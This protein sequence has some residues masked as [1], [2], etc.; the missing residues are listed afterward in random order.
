M[1]SN[2][3][4]E[5]FSSAI[6]L[7]LISKFLIERYPG[8]AEYPL[9]GRRDM[10]QSDLGYGALRRKL[11]RLGA[12]HTGGSRSPTSRRDARET[13]RREAVWLRLRRSTA[14]GKARQA[15][16]AL[17]EAA[18]EALG[19]DIGFCCTRPKMPHKLSMLDQDFWPCA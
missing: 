4:L 2:A 6:H 12:T 9:L 18:P 1:A 14:L 7:V 15:S 19:N 17:P 13:S 5:L 11:C 3:E 16:H 8:G 10:S